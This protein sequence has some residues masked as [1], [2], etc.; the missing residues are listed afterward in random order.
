MEFPLTHYMEAK[1]VNQQ[2]QPQHIINLNIDTTEKLKRAI[3]PS[4]KSI[5]SYFIFY[6]S[7]QSPFHVII[8]PQTEHTPPPG[9]IHSFRH[10]T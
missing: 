10:A 3:P 8:L 1:R 9:L 2:N 4:R 7:L 6:V 5:C